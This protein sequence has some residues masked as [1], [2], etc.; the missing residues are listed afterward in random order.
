MLS[1]KSSIQ[2]EEMSKHI[3]ILHELKGDGWI[4]LSSKIQN[5]YQ[6]HHYKYTKLFIELQGLIEFENIYVSQNTFYKPQRRIENIRQIRACYV[7]IDCYRK[8]YK[9]EQVLFFI[10]E[11]IGEKIPRPNLVIDSGRGLN[12]IWRI[13]PVPYQALSLWS[14][15]ENYL[16]E[17]LKEWGADRVA[18]D[19]TRILRIS[20]TINSKTKAPVRLIETYEH[21][22]TLRE[23]Q[24]EYLPEL[25]PKKIKNHKGRPKKVV[26]LF[27]QYTLYHARLMDLVKICELRHYKIKDYHMREIILFLYRYWTCCFEKDTKEALER[28]LELNQEFDYPLSEREVIRNTKSAEKAFLSK[29]KEYKYTNKTL[30]EMLEI[31]E[32]E[33]KHLKTIIGTKEKYR[34]K[35]YKRNA[36]RRNEKGLTQREQAKQEKIKKIKALSA[37][38]LTLNEIASVIGIHKATVSKYLKST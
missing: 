2:E 17:Q 30:I 3:K 12:L 38:G 5:H 21:I 14:A 16:Y 37:Q 35:N 4:T 29:D 26:S 22:Y 9:K 6:Q 32:E 27:N 34:R 24:N 25:S 13:D 33:Q 20:G 23:I 31:T 18:T 28:S 1:T 15:I 7:D 10:N 11:I 36:K 8:N 19:P